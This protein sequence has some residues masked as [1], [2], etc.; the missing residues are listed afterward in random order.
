[1]SYVW[2]CPG[3]WRL[4]QSIP[5]ADL[6]RGNEPDEFM[7]SGNRIDKARETG[8]PLDLT[9]EES[10]LYTQG[11]K[12]EDLLIQRWLAEIGVNECEEGPRK[13]RLFLSSAETME[14]IVS[15]ES[16]CHYVAQKDG[17]KYVAI[18]DWKFW[19]VNVPKAT[20]N[21]QLRV[22]AILKNVDMDNVAGIRVAVN[23]CA[24]RVAKNDYSDYTPDDLQRSEEWLRYHLWWTKQEDAPLTPGPWCA[25][26]PAQAFCPQAASYAMLPS[27]IAQRALPS[28]QDVEAMVAA[29]PTVD[30][31]KLW[32]TKTIVEKI[33]KAVVIRLKA[34]P[35]EELTELGLGLGKGRSMNPITKT[36][37]CFAFLQNIQNWSED[38]LWEALEFSNGKLAAIAM[39]EKNL[40]KDAASKWVKAALAE[41]IT[42][43]EADPPLKRIAHE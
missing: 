17:K 11:L 18:L 4:R 27:V 40:S 28:S 16:D 7:E 38:D 23:R 24:D 21:T 31:V 19:G 25:Y 1:M 30:L 10:A 35:T 6:E 39:K 2:A 43:S 41:F 34:L 9:E 12:W 3:S 14:P 37:L 36:R 42:A 33:L 20:R 26:C 32:E 8:L 29:L 5:Q 13:E 15:G 22:L